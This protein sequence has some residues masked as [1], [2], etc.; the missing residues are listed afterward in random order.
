MEFRN[1][2]WSKIPLAAKR[3]KFSLTRPN[4]TQ[5]VLGGNSEP[6][7]GEAVL[8][9]RIRLHYVTSLAHPSDVVNVGMLKFHRQTV[10]WFQDDHVSSVLKGAPELSSVQ[11][12]LQVSLTI[13]RFCLWIV[14]HPIKATAVFVILVSSLRYVIL[15]N[16]SDIEYQTIRDL[17]PK[18]ILGCVGGR[19]KH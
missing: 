3:K 16:S 5:H 1:N 2:R 18:E 9:G 14:L 17:I 7:R 6:F 13:D 15:S 10:S 12:Q 19:V 11:S 8:H 4:E